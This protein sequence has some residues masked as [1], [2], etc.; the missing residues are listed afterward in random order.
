MFKPR[1]SVSIAL[2]AIAVTGIGG[3]AISPV[4]ANEPRASAT[5]VATPLTSVSYSTPAVHRI[6]AVPVTPSNF[7]STESSA[8]QQPAAIAEAVATTSAYWRAQSSSRVSF[9]L[10]G[11]AEWHASAFTCQLSEDQPQIVAEAAAIAA[12]ELG[13]EKALNN[14]LLLVYPIGS[15]CD[16][17][18]LDGSSHGSTLNSGGVVAVSGTLSVSDQA[19]LTRQLGYNLS[20][21]N[22]G[23][24]DCPSWTSD[25]YSCASS[26]QGD[27][28]D[29][30]GAGLEQ[31]A[32]GALSSPSAIRSGL[33]PS[34]AFSNAP[35]G[36]TT[37]TLTSISSNAGKRAVAVEGTSGAVFYVEFRNFTGEDAPYAGTH[38]GEAGC[39]TAEPGVRILRGAMMSNGW[40]T[41]YKSAPGDNSALFTVGGDSEFSVGQKISF[42]G[43]TISIAAMTATTASVTV[44]VATHPSTLDYVY[45]VPFERY[46]QDTTSGYEIRV[47]DVWGVVLGEY[48]NF[49]SI[50]YQWTRNGVAIAGETKAYYTLSGSDRGAVV[51]VN[52]TFSHHGRQPFTRKYWVNSFDYGATP[53]PQILPGVLNQGAVAVDQSSTTLAAKT[54][55]WATPATKFSYA[56]YRDASVIAGATGRTYVPVSADRGRAITVRVKGSRSGFNSL[57][58]SSAPVSV[59]I[60]ATGGAAITGQ[61]KV[62]EVV[63][64]QGPMFS[65]SNDSA[66]TRTYQW[67]RSGVAISRATRSTY[68]L[69]ALDLGKTLRVRVTARAPGHLTTASTSPSTLP[70]TKGTIAGEPSISVEATATGLI[71]TV[72]GITESG[73]AKTYSWYRGSARISGATSATYKLTSSDKNQSIRFRVVVSKPG[74]ASLSLVSAPTNYTITAVNGAKP[75]ITDLSPTVGQPT[76]VTVPEYSVAPSTFGYQWL[77]GGVPIAGATGAEFTPTAA[78]AGKVLTVTVAARKVGYF[79]SVLSSSA[80]SPVTLAD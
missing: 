17:I 36:T 21:G 44:T 12:D 73:I 43:I 14:H 68:A 58:A 39:Y 60:T 78:Q 2:V 13:Y 65:S 37:H 79:T 10:E 45:L 24:L 52:L 32:P 33:W 53:G 46:D 18:Y 69:T 22:A 31:T 26:G 55:G 74:F 59:T 15:E 50:A 62:G 51:A 27:Q 61:V 64:A 9:S 38:C 35:N 80:T 6:F 23:R 11:V 72:T 30:M 34:T 28:V 63:E 42:D 5:T 41:S 3:G 66:V 7:S 76:S 40:P 54:T 75:V 25:V 1:V 47:G 77:A 71:G 70:V 48:M 16:S 4:L 19:D 8:D 57:N 20:L 67:Y 56:W 29:P 49:D